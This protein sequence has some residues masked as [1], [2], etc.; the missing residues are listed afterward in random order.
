MWLSV[1]LIGTKKPTQS[2]TYLT[3]SKWRVKMLFSIFKTRV[4]G[5]QI[6][7]PLHYDTHPTLKIF[8]RTNV[9]AKGV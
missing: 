6:V 8:A 2:P 5:G 3:I 1:T 7:W 9:T 4:F